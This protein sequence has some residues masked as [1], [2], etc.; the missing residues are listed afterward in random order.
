M[1]AWQIENEPNW[2]AMHETGGWRSGAAWLEAGGF[3]DELLKALHG[4]VHEE[5]PEAVTI[6][7]L[8]ADELRTGVAE[9][10]R[11]CDV[12]GLDF[13]PNYKA[14]EPVGAS[15][16]RRAQQFAKE[17]GK[18]VLVAETGYPSGPS[19][20]GY[21]R[22][23]Q[24]D[25]VGNALKEAY[26]LDQVMGIG[27]WRYLDTSWKSFPPQENHFGLVDENEGPKEAWLRYAD[28]VKELRR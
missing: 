14:P 20:L 21:S 3:R 8:E 6:I 11:F 4:A 25:Y 7:N 13:Y 2:W 16:I 12:I 5:D 22:E 9:Y 27:I 17:A 19:L 23:K 24:A 10:T 26:S 1:K 28:V 18:P 15:V